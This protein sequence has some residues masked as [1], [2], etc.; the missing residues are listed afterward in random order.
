MSQLFDPEWS[1]NPDL[2]RNPMTSKIIRR[3]LLDLS[4]LCLFPKK[5]SPA[6]RVLLRMCVADSQAPR[7][8]KQTDVEKF[9]RFPQMMCA[10][11]AARVDVVDARRAS[12]SLEDQAYDFVIVPD[13]QE[14]A[15]AKEFEEVEVRTMTWVKQCIITGRLVR[16]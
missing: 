11:G 5:A 3:P 8:P 4:V 15:V 10:M 16:L 2:P 13:G 1:T 7:Q 14:R 12:R 6:T 9:E